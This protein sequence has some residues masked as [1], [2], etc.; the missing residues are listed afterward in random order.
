MPTINPDD[1]IISRKRKL[2]KFA[3]FQNLANCYD[4]H[5][6]KQLVDKIQNDKRPLTIEVGA[7]SAL[8]LTKLAAIHPNRQFVAIDRKSDRL[9]KGA[10]LASQQNISNIYYLWSNADQLS[11][12]FSPHSVQQIWLTF[13]D[14]WPQESNIKH[15]LTNPRFLA[16]YAKLLD[17]SGTLNFKTDN[18]ALFNW[19]LDQ[20][21]TANWRVIVSTNQLHNPTTQN[22]PIN[23][24]D[25]IMTTYEERYHKA[26]N[27]IYYLS[28]T[29]P[30]NYSV[31]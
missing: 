5:S 19:S 26:G 23:E 16:D 13:P 8:F 9:Q 21:H 14:P 28:A 20:L 10:K 2:Y 17:P 11:T 4:G 7:G 24:D 30:D 31:D 25:H 3:V 6:L 22:S 1:F 18:Q 15:R 27:S 29:A 12:I